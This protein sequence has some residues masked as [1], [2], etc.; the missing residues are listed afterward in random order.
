MACEL[1]ERRAHVYQWPSR[2]HEGCGQCDSRHIA[3]LPRDERGS[4]LRG[5]EL[6]DPKKFREVMREWEEDSYPI[7]VERGLLCLLT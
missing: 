4:I 2:S 6:S 3:R 5:L 7:L 1:C